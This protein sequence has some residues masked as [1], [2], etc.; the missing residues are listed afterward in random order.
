MTSGPTT[1]RPHP[2]RTPNK[3]KGHKRARYVPLRVHG[4]HSFLAGVDSP[5]ELLERAA[6]LGLP[7]LALT[8]IDHCAGAVELLQAAEELKGARPIIGAE[9]SDPSGQPGRAICLVESA[10]GWRNLCRLLSARQLGCDPGASDTKT[11][12]LSDFDLIDALREWNEGLII[13]VDHPRLLLG[14]MDRLPSRQVLAA[15]SPA[16]LTKRSPRVR[17]KTRNT[18]L[19][20][21]AQHQLAKERARTLSSPPEPSPL[22]P[23]KTPAPARAFDIDDLLDAARATGFAAVAVPDVYHAA[24]GARADHETRAAIRAGALLS[25][26]PEEWAAPKPSHLPTHAELCALFDDI[27]D[28]PGAWPVEVEAEEPALVARTRAIAEACRY[29]PT[30]GSAH[31][32]AVELQSGESPYSELCGLAF[33]GARERYRPLRPEVVRRLDSELNTIDSLGFAPYFLLCERIASWARDVGIPCV[34]RGSAADSLVAYC[35]GLTDA[36]PFRYRLI[37]E[38]FL[39]S[40]R[41]DRPD[42]DLDFCWRRRDEVIEHVYGLFGRERTAMIATINCFGL[43]AAFREAALTEGVPPALVNR[44]SKRLPYT[45]FETSQDSPNRSSNPIV[46]AL[47]DAPEASDFPFEDPRWQ[48][49]L[50]RAASLIDAPRHFGLHP[51]GVL[52]SPGPITDFVPCR[53]SSKGVVTASFDKDAV[54]AIGL[55]KMD[56][57]GN[58]A[59]TVLSDCLATLART[60]EAPDIEQLDE[61]DQATTQL[62]AE[63]R[64]LGCFQI[65]S[66]GMRHLLQ[67]TSR[68]TESD[69]GRLSGMDAVIQAVALIRPGPAGSGMKDTYVRRANG[70][71]EPTPPHPRLAELLRDTHGVMLYQEDVMQAAS[72][73]AGMD[74]AE[75]D[76]LRRALCKRDEDKTRSARRRFL[77]GCEQEGLPRE[78]TTELWELIANFAAFGFCKAHAVTYGR[79]AYRCA[80]LKAHHPAAFMHAF[81]ESHTGYYAPRVYL[82]EAR[83]MGVGVLGP[84]INKSGAGYTL[85]HRDRSHAIRIGLSLIKGMSQD[86]VNRSLLSREAGGAFLSLPDFLERTRAH[87]DEAAAL[88]QC[89]AFDRSDRTRP[90]LMWRLHLLRKRQPALRRRA[91]AEA[92][93][94]TGSELDPALLAACKETPSAREDNRVATARA[95]TR[96][97]SGGLGLGAVDLNDGESTSLFPA[98]ET[99][100]LA[101]PALPDLTPSEQA[102]Y[103]HELLGF[104]LSGHPTKVFTSPSEARAEEDPI[105]PCSCV[106]LSRRIGGRVTLS[107]WPIATRRV[108]TSDGRWMR[109]LTLEDE[110]GIAEVVIF[111]DV[112]ERDGR[113]LAEFGTHRIC[114][115]IH[116]QMGAVTLHAEK[117]L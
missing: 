89:G 115:V 64:T 40:T 35:L 72:L 38:R 114:G 113:R 104:S 100:S 13:L 4:H 37:F 14:L 110:T 109:F 11:P 41:N 99:P 83:R 36:D 2:V 15:L 88:I 39:N 107:A 17:L 10:E 44:W 45:S 66:P 55:V 59:L 29:V 61:N 112:Y 95:N 85:E 6:T 19:D 79:I 21:E 91:Q 52:V 57:L 80:W 74:L 71:E 60:G 82:E 1:P 28:L 73:L 34:G 5:R 93:S 87:T 92:R 20:P 50:D 97:W 31:F 53:R 9:L 94:L 24:P 26:L 62:L 25:E 116:D 117:I 49:V 27:P 101:L 42:I 46:R 86:T 103:E 56:L 75:A 111:A 78:V 18:H 54:E 106:E 58:R 51:G 43:R 16:A 32:P 69:E 30:L 67:Q 48:R 76:L 98:P 47:N 23:D 68:S 77:R 108:R 7:A 90:E 12:P 81:L 63:G 33:D 105:N 96:G 65:E 84:D 22:E 8:D 70:L 102:T 3:S